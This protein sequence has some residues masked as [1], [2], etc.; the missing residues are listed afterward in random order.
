MRAVGIAFKNFRSGNL[1]RAIL[2]SLNELLSYAD[3]GRQSQI[4]KALSERRGNRFQKFSAR[5]FL[6]AMIQL[7]RFQKN[8]L[9]SYVK[10]A[11]I[12][13]LK[14]LNERRGNRVQNFRRGEFFRSILEFLN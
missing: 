1:L 12:P 2:E 10:G 6:H 7:P 4:L 5:I 9:H 14:A 8:K 11:P 13:F 3:F